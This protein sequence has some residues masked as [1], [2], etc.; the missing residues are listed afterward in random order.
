MDAGPDIMTDE[1]PLSTAPPAEEADEM[2]GPERRCIVT[3]QTRPREEMVRFV[4]GPEGAVQA[5]FDG[6]L[7]GRGMWV[8]AE[9]RLIER[10]VSER[11]FERA[12][13]M[14]AKSHGKDAASA[15]SVPVDLV[16]QVERGLLRR[17]MGALGLARR[18][19]QA[20]VGFDQ[21]C[22]WVAAGRA[23]VVLSARDGAA[24]GRGKMRAAARELPL[25][26][27]LDSDEL[28]RALGRE[29]VVHVAIAGRAARLVMME[30]ARLQGLRGSEGTAAE[31][32]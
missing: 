11:L 26:S 23:A 1:R 21:V 32:R 28:G 8:T 7:P 30:A 10:A 5:D 16:A 12:L 29:R 27:S 2:G 6:N 15:P 4:V 22:E 31:D 18:A 3:R 13:K 24:G 19:G 14:A 9:R 20:A 17:L 25:L